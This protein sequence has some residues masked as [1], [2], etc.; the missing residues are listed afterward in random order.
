[1]GHGAGWD[2]AR[3]DLMLLATS[4][5]LLAAGAGDGKVYFWQNDGKL[6][7]TVL[8]AGSPTL[9]ATAPKPARP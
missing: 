2:A 8:S 4:I 1:M 9:A 7:R 6:I 3:I 5:M